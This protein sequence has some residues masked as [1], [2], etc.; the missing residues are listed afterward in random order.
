MKIG[1]QDGKGVEIT[2]LFDKELGKENGFLGWFSSQEE[3]EK[4]AAKIGLISVGIE[5]KIFAMQNIETGKVFLIEKIKPLPSNM[6][7]FGLNKNTKAAMIV[8]IDDDAPI[9]LNI[10]QKKIITDSVSRTDLN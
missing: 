9:Q 10:I 2:K 6:V 1:K 3:A 5:N 7:D 8:E 4:A